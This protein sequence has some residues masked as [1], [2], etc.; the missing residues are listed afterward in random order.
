[1]TAVIEELVARNPGSVEEVRLAARGQ[2]V[3][4]ETAEQAAAIA[5]TK[6]SA[7]A[8]QD[9]SHEIIGEISG[10]GGSILGRYRDWYVEPLFDYLD[11]FLE[12]ANIILATLVRYKHKV[13]WYRRAELQALHSGDTSKGEKRLA[14][15]MYEYLFD[16]GIPFHIEPEGASGRPDI[17]AL[18]DSQDPFI[19]DTKI[20]DGEGRGAPY[21]RKGLYQVYRYC[22][23]HNEAVGYLIIFN[24]S[25][26]QLYFRLQAGQTDVP[27]FEY[28]NKTIF[29]IIIDLYAHEGTASTRPVPETVTISREDLVQEADEDKRNS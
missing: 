10:N 13:E 19:G 2:D 26:K 29:V 16:Q 1:L 6:W 20:F 18:D 21:I 3:Y 5:H 14:K 9:N 28:N 15:H 7:F 23:D 17:I 8:A 11:E 22:W 27:R 12:D 24:I 4:G 25:D